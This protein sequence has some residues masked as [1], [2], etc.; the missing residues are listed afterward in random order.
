[1]QKKLLA[2]TCCWQF[3]QVSVFSAPSAGNQ[4]NTGTGLAMVSHKKFV[5][6][7]KHLEIRHFHA[8]KHF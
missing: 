5:A 8:S 6:G 3:N 2:T 4:Q 1:M 7:H